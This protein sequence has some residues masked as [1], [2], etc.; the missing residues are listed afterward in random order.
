MKIRKFAAY[1][2]NGI[3]YNLVASNPQ[4][5][6]KFRSE[7]V[8]LRSEITTTNGDSVFHIRKGRYRIQNFL[9]QLFINVV[10]RDPNAP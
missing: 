10:S 2:A 6:L 7:A 4:D 1:D 5:D 3:R 9:K 8:D